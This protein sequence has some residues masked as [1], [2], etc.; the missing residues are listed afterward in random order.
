[1]NSKNGFKMKFKNRQI[2]L[3]FHTS[4]LIPNVAGEFDEQQFI[5]TLKTAEVSGVCLFAR[6]HHGYCYYP[7]E[8]GTIH[9]HLKENDL[10]GKQLKVLKENGIQAGLYTTICW[11]EL[12]ADKHPEW[13]CVTADNEVMKMDP[14]TGEQK[15]KFE[16]GWRFLCWNSPYREFFK[17]HLADLLKKYSAEYFF[18]DI[19]FTYTPCACGYCIDRMKKHGL[20]PENKNDRQKNSIDSAREFMDHIS[21]MIRKYDQDIGIFYNG[22][23]RVTGETHKGSIPELD[24][25][26]G[27]IIESLPS[28][29]WG[30]DHFPVLARYFQNFNHSFLGHTG[31]FQKMWGDFG[32]LKN[33][34]ALDYEVIRMMSLGVNA[35]VGDQMHPRG[36]L[37]EATYELIGN[38]FRKVKPL[39]KV[40]VPSEPVDEIAVMLTN[41]GKEAKNIG[42]ELDP[43]TG[44]MKLLTQ[45][46]YQFS[47]VDP[48]SDISKYK[49]LILPDHV[50]ITDELKDKIE[51]FV[52]GGGS[53]L[54]SYSSILD[55]KNSIAIFDPFIKEV[56]ELE[57]QPHYFYP[58]SEEIC[59]GVADTDHVF[60][61]KAKKVQTT[62]NSEI[63]CKMTMPFFNREW[64]HFCS[65]LQTPPDKR[66]DLP[67]VVRMG[68]N[69]VYIA[70][71]FFTCFHK[72]SSRVL[73]KVIDH[74]I[75]SLINEKL[76]ETNLPSTS[77]VTLRKN[78]TGQYVLSILNYVPQRRSEGID[79]VEDELKLTDIKISLSVPC[80]GQVT[81]L[82]RNKRI[83]TKKINGRIE[84]QIDEI[85]GFVVITID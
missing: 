51:E 62:E 32:G 75:R 56:Q 9:P 15:N 57:Y 80:Q 26:N 69:G 25:Q 1:M 17:E 35:C 31:K 36:V 79:I 77:E 14:L 65:H 19:L 10:L 83:E 82:I 2:H 46:Q 72:Y 38:T 48:K 4:G 20:D 29:P 37:D 39:Q 7:T 54:A 30:Y 60:Y 6:C 11:D 47:F 63:L 13:V 50:I 81:D 64:D 43:E 52:T 28:G 22:R 3:D 24:Y 84:F 58:N 59:K 49:L 45:L 27:I 67:E 85:N 70:G 34:A 41:A 53:V 61:L 40:L 71:E 18:L 76:V 42:A 16:P 21:S 73:K 55:E 68:D 44:A 23:L 74:S 66:T 5:K 8:K 12:T 78:Q 33:Q